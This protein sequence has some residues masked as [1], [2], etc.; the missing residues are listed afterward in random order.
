[1]LKWSMEGKGV[2]EGRN[3]W[4]SKWNNVGRE[5]IIVEVKWWEQEGPIHYSLCFCMF[6]IFHSQ[7]FKNLKAKTNKKYRGIKVQIWTIVEGRR[8]VIM[9]GQEGDFWTIV[10]SLFLDLLNGYAG[11]Y[12]VMLLNIYILCNSLVFYSNQN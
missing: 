1:M 4:D 5:L 8:G 10:W 11:I 9:R 12:F 3:G 6:D 7:K 2:V